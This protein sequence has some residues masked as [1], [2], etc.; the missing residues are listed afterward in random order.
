MDIGSSR[1]INFKMK[2]QAITKYYRKRTIYQI[3]LACEMGIGLVGI[4]SSQ[5]YYGII[6]IVSI[7]LM[8]IT[9]SIMSYIHKY[10]IKN[11]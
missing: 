7:V 1:Q 3:C 5:K 6:A 10:F 8:A 2:Q 9:I 4:W 11:N